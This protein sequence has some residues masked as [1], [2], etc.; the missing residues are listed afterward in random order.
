MSAF[1]KSGEK[2]TTPYRT[3]GSGIDAQG[4]MVWHRPITFVVVAIAIAVLVC[5]QLSISTERLTVQCRTDARKLT[6]SVN[7]ARSWGST[8]DWISKDFDRTRGNLEVHGSNGPLSARLWLL[9]LRSDRFLIPTANVTFFDGRT[10]RDAIDG[11]VRH[12]SWSANGAEAAEAFVKLGTSER[13]A[14]QVNQPL[15]NL[16]FLQKLSFALLLAF[17]V[18]TLSVHRITIHIFRSDRRLLTLHAPAKARAEFKA[19]ALEGEAAEL[20]VIADE[21]NKFARICVK[22]GA[23]MQ[24]DVTEWV[25]LATAK[26]LANHAA[27]LL[28]TA[29][30]GD[31]IVFSRDSQRHFR[32][33]VT[34]M[35]VATV[36]PFVGLVAKLPPQPWASTQVL[37]Q[38]KTVACRV[39]TNWI[40]EGASSDSL[41]SSIGRHEVIAQS[42]NQDSVKVIYDVEP[43]QTTVVHCED[44]VRAT[45][46]ARAGATVFVSPATGT[47]IQSPE[48][49]RDAL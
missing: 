41:N 22:T 4:F 44:I 34:L 42:L 6:C 17:W 25:P 33:S 3:L 23:G 8:T 39:G 18:I 20:V 2:P 24:G 28:Q 26:L 10:V 7:A 29:L 5:A 14:F 9:A 35:V 19:F 37:I 15:E 30:R 38:S 1:A 43:N 11:P 16:R 47:Y 12:G 21:K 48:R 49:N 45:Q 13:F 46:G 27:P 31:K 32:T 40:A 36:A